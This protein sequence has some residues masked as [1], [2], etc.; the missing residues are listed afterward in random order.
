MN[1]W[2]NRRRII[3]A[4]IVA[5]LCAA[6]ISAGGL[7]GCSSSE[8]V[9]SEEENAQTGPVTAHPLEENLVTDNPYM[10]QDE[11]IIHN[12]VYSS[13]VTEKL[14]PLGIYPEI[15]VS[16]EKEAD[17]A[18]PCC[19]FDTEGNCITPYSLVTEMGTIS[20]G[21]AIRD[22][23]ADPV[24]TLGSFLPVR[25]DEGAK[26]GIQ[27]SY[28]FVDS[29]GL[30]TAATTHGHILMLKTTDD[31]GEILSVFQK[32]VD[33]D[34][35]TKAQNELGE[36]IDPNLMSTV[37][38]YEG[39]LWFTTGGFRINPEYAADGFIGYIDRE[40]IDKAAAGENVDA[41]PYVH[42]YRLGE[43]ESAENG[44]SSHEKGC[45]I[46]TNQACY[47][48]NASEDGVDVVWRTAYSS[49][50]G[51]QP[52]EDS[53]I[54]GAGLAWGG[55]S[56]PTLSDKL[57]LFTDN[58]K[59][60]N[61]IA[62]D[63]DTGEQVASH[64]VFEEM[65]D[66]KVAVENSII[67]YSSDPSRVSALVCNWYGAGNA[68]LYSEDADSSVQAY[69]N[70]YDENWIEKGSECL[71]PGIERLDTIYKDGS[72][73]MESVWLRSDICDTSM[74][75]LSTASGCLYGYTEIDG[76]WQYIVLDWETGETVLSVPV[77]TLSN[78]NN[79]AVGMMQGN[80]GNS[81]YVPTNNMELLCLRDRFAYLPEKMF[82]DLD[83][84]QM[85]REKWTAEDGA[86]T[87][88]YLHSAVMDCVYEP[89]VLAV[90][91]NNLE[92]TA[93]ELNLYLRTADG[94]VEKYEGEWQLTDESGEPVDEQQELDPSVI[95]E[96]R[97]TVEDQNNYDQNTETGTVKVSV[98]LAKD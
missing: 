45:V 17:K 16:E 8:A 24:K 50:G 60:V 35:L 15:T 80:N 84:L 67:V 68:G 96:I 38:D 23:D 5:F 1:L 31:N 98:A 12:D 59:P 43:G 22:I 26:Y 62:L 77:S 46:L 65:E 51:E 33:V 37:M 92:G 87:V 6:G 32:A 29:N 18:I 93:Q 14:L 34:V 63:I 2:E 40:Y 19:F 56:T 28:A 4:G 47:L 71:Q 88:T 66:T 42:L 41:N 49:T 20:G 83:I 11:S 25:D 21:V 3:S 97:V 57:V 91:V 82:E 58:Q 85:S 73:T 79:M 94:S 75:K 78:Y 39:N 44:I 64:S 9:Q 81:I 74:L 72:Y 54:T 48:L 13:D 61:L 76:M 70:L 10:A 55:G 27:I 90:R 95:Y 7:T 69:S 89:T 52:Q 86:E 53:D 30:V 36:D